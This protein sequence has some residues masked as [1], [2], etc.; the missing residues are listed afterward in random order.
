MLQS[1]NLSVCSFDI[2]DKDKTDEEYKKDVLAI[3][4]SL[5]D[6][7]HFRINNS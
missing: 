4:W 6:M 3:P 5:K 1:S 2:L 7:I